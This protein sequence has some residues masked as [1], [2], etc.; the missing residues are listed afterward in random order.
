MRWRFLRAP[1]RL[2]VIAAIVFAMAADIPVKSPIA[3][4]PPPAVLDWT[5]WYGGLNYGNAVGR[6]RGTTP[7][8]ANTEFERAD[9]GYTIGLQ[10]GYNWQFDPRW[11]VGIEGDIGWLGID[12]T[13]RDWSEL[14]AFGLKLTGTPSSRPRGYSTGRRSST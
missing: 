2:A 10:A 13:R 5:G 7:N 1:R 11:V 8:N 9:D 6:T 4:A 14:Q 12:R 3:K